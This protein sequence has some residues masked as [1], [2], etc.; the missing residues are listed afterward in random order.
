MIKDVSRDNHALPEIIVG[1]RNSRDWTFRNAF[2]RP[3]LAI[4]LH[5][6]IEVQAPNTADFAMLRN[7]KIPAFLLTGAYM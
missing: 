6:H 4:L 3:K 7:M 2:T 1:V 5:F